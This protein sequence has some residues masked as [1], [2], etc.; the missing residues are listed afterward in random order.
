MHSVF[1]ILTHNGADSVALKAAFASVNP[2]IQIF[3]TRSQYQSYDDLQSL[4]KLPHTRNA[5]SVWADTIIDNAGLSRFLLPYVDVMGYISATKTCEA[6]LRREYG[7]RAEDYYASRMM[8]I[9]Q[10]LDRKQGLVISEPGESSPTLIKIARTWFPS[11][12][13]S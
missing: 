4:K 7:D 5:S 2:N 12:N 3:N 1:F 13:L 11:L 10:F 8:A 6:I 9:K